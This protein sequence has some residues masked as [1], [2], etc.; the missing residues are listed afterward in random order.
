MDRLHLL[1]RARLGRSQP[2]QLAEA[3][4]SIDTEARQL[5]DTLQA[6]PEEGMEKVDLLLSLWEVQALQSLYPDL[7]EDVEVDSDD[8]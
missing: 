5:L 1:A 8:D 7:F 3:L 2:E 6:D 4:S